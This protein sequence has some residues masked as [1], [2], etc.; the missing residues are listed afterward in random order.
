V[1]FAAKV[2]VAVVHELPEEEVKVN[3]GDVA[4]PVAGNLLRKLSRSRIAIYR[5]VRPSERA[6]P[7][8]RARERPSQAVEDHARVE[9]SAERFFSLSMGTH[10]GWCFARLT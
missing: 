2:N 6:T 8:M 4:G 3:R 9:G 7:T 1:P 5:D 10:T